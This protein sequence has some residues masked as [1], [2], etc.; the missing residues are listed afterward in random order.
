[1]NDR[2][3]GC[4]ETR[5]ARDV[6]SPAFRGGSTSDAAPTTLSASAA[7]A[8]ST[9]DAVPPYNQTA[10]RPASIPLS[11][12]LS[13]AYL[14]VDVASGLSASTAAARLETYGPNAL[15]QPPGKSLLRLIL[16]QFDDR[17]VQILLAVAALSGVFS[18]FEMRAAGE[19]GEGLLRSFVEPLVILAILL[20]NASVG[21]WQSKSAE[22]SLEA[23][24]KLQPSLASVLRDGEWIDGMDASE[25]V[26]GD[27]IAFRVGDK[28]SADGRLVQLKTSTVSVDEGS[29][30]GE[31]MTVQ[32]LPGDEGLVEPG[33][34]VQDQRGC[35]FAGTV[36]TSG[37]GLAVVTRTGMATEIGKIQEGI[38]G[39]KEGSR[40]EHRTPLERKL[41]DFGDTL[42][43]II[44]V[45][46]LAVW[47]VSIPKFSDPSFDSVLEGAIY[48]AK[49]AVALG[50]AAIPE[51][52]PAVI[53]LC[54]SLG[55]RRMA[56]RN[57]IVRKL[58]SVETLG[59][60]SVIATD[61][62]G[63]LTTNE[64]TAVSL[65]LL[66]RDSA[67]SAGGAVKEYPIDGFSYSPIGV[68]NGI[69][70]DEEIASNPRGSVADVAAVSALCND[71]KIVGR[72]PAAEAAAAEADGGKKKKKEEASK[73]YARVG[74]PTEAALCVLAEK[75]GGMKSAAVEK[76]TPKDLAAVNV[77][78]WRSSRPRAATLEFSRDRKSMSVLCKSDGSSAGVTQELDA[79]GPEPDVEDVVP[80]APAKRRRS[81][82][83]SD[84]GERVPFLLSKVHAKP[85]TSSSAPA[86]DPSM[87]P[88]EAPVA[89][90]VDAELLTDGDDSSKNWG[91]RLL[92]KG[93][94][95]LLLERCTRV[96]Y[97]DG[98][99]APLTAEL[100][101]EIEGKVSELA[102]RPLRCLALA[103]KETPDLEASLRYYEPPE[104]E[105][106]TLSDSESNSDDEGT[107][108][109]DAPAR[110]H[111]LLSDPKTYRD[112][113][114]GLTL[115]GIVGI[116]DPARPEVRDSI[117]EC[118]EAGIRVLMI[119]GDARDTA[120]AIARD[121]NIFPPKPADQSESEED[122][123][124]YEGR[125]F[126]LKPESEQLE[127]L[128]SGNMVF[129]RAE[130]AD[131]QKLVKML[132][133]LG[134]IPAMTGDGVNDAPALQQ[135]AIGIAMGI[136]GTEVA[137]EAADMILADDNFSTIVSAVEEGRCIYANMQAFICF[138]ISCNIGEIAAILLATVAGF[139]EPLTAMHLLWVN[140]V[141]DGPPATAL[142]FNP[143]APD[144]MQ[145]RPRPSDEP[146][147]TRWLLTRYCL[148]GL[149]VGLATVGVFVGHYMSL[150]VSLSD[151]GS[152]SKC[153]ELWTPAGGTA[154]MC[155]D[156]FGATGRML[157]QTL[158]LT[159]LVCM[160][161][162][163][164]LSAVSVDSSL[165]TVGPQSNPWLM[166]GVAL[167]MLLHL[168]VV[169]SPFLGVPGLG[170]AFGIVPL[171]VEDW[172]TILQWSAPII[173]V[174]EALKFVGRIVNKKRDEELV[175]AAEGS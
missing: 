1:M 39:A 126:F 117:R 166:A 13:P 16:E 69:A 168:A 128:K 100:R 38:I 170:E 83:S 88:T 138:L 11:A 64:M 109:A 48:Y 103:V 61:K 172:I 142:G 49:V 165:L 111:P 74:E 5:R 133:S 132:Q 84:D 60:T 164:A 57:V 59:C 97:R 150:G 86:R 77:D 43:I 130:P 174:D 124:A 141:T 17:L 116:K 22:G 163:K 67:S 120:V 131:K 167:P 173:L 94:P 46:C 44:G 9:D 140:L 122:L 121:V 28:I 144:L 53:T 23:L 36:V 160:E 66:E 147:M 145:Q 91:N 12:L 56:K 152:W 95:N 42:T 37:S 143:P 101:R 99:V 98:T 139:P 148:T 113:E 27:V 72:D 73:D 19:D 6:L 20:L 33:A 82:S 40:A 81:S 92:V 87:A 78:E 125:E 158:S 90:P 55:T 153:G 169:Y 171:S 162:F 34:P 8:A 123:K 149:Y 127:L 154:A 157:P 58:P 104:E 71:A 52:L 93:A 106:V 107:A 41:E 25:L 79:L 2:R 137:K 3:R 29:L 156:L 68:V 31:S 80:S 54:L 129:C 35:V 134:E 14:D 96:K 32:K 115:V 105:G 110:V 10:A 89:E 50:V 151:L 75:L 63:T 45:I 119:T 65:V 108:A 30:T 24:K 70:K 146:I 7:S 102:R 21:V 15:V 51:G 85:D 47:V 161:M 112:I 76:P 155:E 26:P 159:T 4:L 118:T 114:S 175:A 62:T 136:T 18:F 135:A